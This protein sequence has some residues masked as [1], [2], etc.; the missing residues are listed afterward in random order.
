MT[1][2]KIISILAVVCIIII[3]CLAFILSDKELD[4]ESE[5]V[6]SLYKYL[7]EVDIY[8][9]GG[10]LTYSENTVTKDTLSVS[11]KLCMAYYELSDEQK[12]SKNMDSTEINKNDLKIC[13][14][15]ENAVFTTE[16]DQDYC[17]YVE[18]NLNDLNQAYEK[19]YGEN[20]TSQDS[21]YITNSDACYLEGDVYYCG[22][23]ETFTYSLM[24][25]ATIYRLLN[26]AV[27][28]L[29]GDIVI[30]D[31]YLKVSNDKCYLANDTSS[32]D[33]TCTKA[34]KDTIDA[35]FVRKYAALYKHTYQKDENG[36]Y[37]WVKS[38]LK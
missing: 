9:C 29:N 12:T 24:P 15:G 5:Q 26:K 32:E 11:N 10:L 36:N 18:I 14:V 7:G 17:S 6:K 4:L 37:Y 2:K 3:L 20:N 35:E 22:K 23:A 33:T 1:K 31:Y 21:F 38:E 27:T 13:K 34:L 30:Y 8:H 16:D 28:K 19:I 25:E